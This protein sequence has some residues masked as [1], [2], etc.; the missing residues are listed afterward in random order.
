M[1]I[2]N[3]ET[4]EIFNVLN[5]IKRNIGLAVCE[6]MNNQVERNKAILNMEN[7]FNSIIENINDYFFMKKT[8]KTLKIEIKLNY[9]S[10]I[11][12]WNDKNHLET[13]KIDFA[14][15]FDIPIKDIEIR[16]IH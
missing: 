3:L 6:F 9:I 16:I 13:L 12:Y 15:K 7:R 8:K 5:N 14:H 10:D 4:K 2:K 11:K 1:S